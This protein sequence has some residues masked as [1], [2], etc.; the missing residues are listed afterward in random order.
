MQFQV[1]TP[2][3]YSADDA[4]QDM[5]VAPEV[6]NVPQL[7]DHGDTIEDENGN[8]IT[9]PCIRID[10]PLSNLENHI[11][12]RYDEDGK[13]KAPG[14]AVKLPSEFKLAGTIPARTDG[15]AKQASSKAVAGTALSIVLGFGG[16]KSIWLSAKLAIDAL[17]PKK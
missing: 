16:A 13:A 12:V 15:I 1:L 5:T 14:F 2:G 11:G 6:V 7:N 3:A 9:V 10:I 4:P 17:P 8:A